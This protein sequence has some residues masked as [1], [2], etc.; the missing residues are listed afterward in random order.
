MLGAVE[1]LGR[2]AAAER[3]QQDA[4]WVDTVADEVREAGGERSGLAGARAGDDQ[5]V[6]AVVLRRDPLLVGQHLEHS[7]E[8]SNYFRKMGF[9]TVVNDLRSWVWMR[10]AVPSGPDVSQRRAVNVCVKLLLVIA[11]MPTVNPSRTI[12]IS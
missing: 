9:P 3:E 5:Q 12:S 7:F 4:G 10:H 8:R 2:G 6:A 11:T 1:Q